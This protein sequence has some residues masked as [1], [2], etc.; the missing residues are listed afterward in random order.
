MG[1]ANEPNYSSDLIAWEQDALHSRED[2][3]VLAG[4]GSDRALL[5]GQVLGR[6]SKG[7]PTSAAKSGGNTGDGAM[8]AVTL[9]AEAVPGVYKLRITKA[10]ANA[11]DFQVTDPQGDV[12]GVGTVGVAFAGAHLNFTL[13]D[14][15]A[16]FIVGDGFDITVPAGAGKVKEIDFAATD[17]TE[18]AYGV[19]VHAVT[20]PNGVDARGVA[21]VRDADLRNTGLVWPGGATDAQKSAALDQLAARGIVIRSVA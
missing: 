20:A 16:D 19:L 2:V 7:P 5:V 9:G 15:S 8:G 17:G 3:T 6:Q 12:I 21:I 1:T 18:D 10:A 11:G 4:S 14:G 13:A